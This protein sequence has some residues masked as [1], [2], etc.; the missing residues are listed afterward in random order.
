M[1][2]NP[3]TILI[4]DDDV[5]ICRLLRQLLDE[6]YCLAEAN[7]GEEALAMF[8]GFAPHLVMLDIMMPGI[9]GQETCRQMRSHPSTHGLQIVM[10]SAESSREEQMRAYAAGADDYIVKPFDQYALCSR[11]RLHFRLRDAILVRDMENG[12]R[13]RLDSLNA[14]EREA[15]AKIVEGVPNKTIAHQLGLS[16]RTTNRIRATVFKKMGVV[17]A[18][19]LAR[20]VGALGL[21][22]RQNDVAPET[23]AEHRHGQKHRRLDHPAA[24]GPPHNLRQ[25]FR[26]V[27]ASIDGG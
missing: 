20:V 18:V 16:H 21:D 26:D 17:S 4:V 25:G 12:L 19:D 24:P 10:V 5:A 1:Q 23:P 2:G 6:E 8:A 9:D 22:G 7:S 13:L 27:A 3:K 11:V 14:R 15:L